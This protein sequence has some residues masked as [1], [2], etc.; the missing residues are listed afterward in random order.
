MVR[1]QHALTSDLKSEPR[2]QMIG[3]LVVLGCGGGD[4]EGA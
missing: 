1:G 2:Q 4:A 3:V